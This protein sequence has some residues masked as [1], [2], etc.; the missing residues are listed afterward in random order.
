MTNMPD[1]IHIMSTECIKCI[2]S[3]LRNFHNMGFFLTEL[4]M[5]ADMQ[6]LYLKK[7]L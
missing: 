4:S 2:Y 5:M 6:F 7:Y 1:S 3:T